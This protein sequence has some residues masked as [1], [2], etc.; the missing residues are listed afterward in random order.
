[1][2]KAQ[3]TGGVET[4][5]SSDGAQTSGDGSTETS[6]SEPSD[7]EVFELLS[8]QRRR[9]VLHYLRRNPEASVSL[10]TLSERVAGWEHDTDPAELAY[11]ER[12]SVRNSLHQFHLPKLADAGI[13]TYD[14]QAGEISLEDPTVVDAY[15]TV[16][17]DGPSVSRTTCVAGVST[18]AVG[19][20][21]LA[22]GA[23]GAGGA[24]AWAIVALAVVIATATVYQAR[25]T[26]DVA[27]GPP[28]ECRG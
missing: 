2:S 27:D 1:M 28:P 14:E 16:S 22:A 13:V 7:D 4:T 8:N 18:T 19:V 15:H 9:F 17:D 11:S 21:G 23:T 26:A 12:K 24:L 25:G 6:E 3:Q 20:L 10:S 5:A